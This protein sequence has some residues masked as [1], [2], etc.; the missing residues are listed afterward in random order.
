MRRMFPLVM[1]ILLFA[2][3]SFVVFGQPERISEEEYKAALASS[4]LRTDSSFPRIVSIVYKRVSTV[5]QSKYEYF[6]SSDR[7]YSKM[8]FA[9]DKESIS[10]ETVIYDG[11]AFERKNGGVWRLLKFKKAPISDNTT[12]SSE[13]VP[14]S[15]I[16]MKEEVSGPTGIAFLYSQTLKYHYGPTISAHTMLDSK[17]RNTRFEVTGFI[18]DRVKMIEY[19]T[20]VTPIKKPKLGSK[21]DI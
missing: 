15:A 13:K 7:S 14:M 21:E 8:L 3:A 19:P 4:T 10:T 16:W 5:R 18:F 20:I 2:V 11:E 17:G 12:E 9:S 6:E 1:V